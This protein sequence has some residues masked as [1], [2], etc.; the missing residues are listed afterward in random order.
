MVRRG[1]V[2]SAS[3]EWRVVRYGKASILIWWGAVHSAT[4]R[5]AYAVLGMVSKGKIW[6]GKARRGGVRWGAVR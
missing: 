3:V 2:P 4:V 1:E 6:L 5:C